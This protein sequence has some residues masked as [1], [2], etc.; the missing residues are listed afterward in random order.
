MSCMLMMMSIIIRI[1]FVEATTPC[2][3]EDPQGCDDVRGGGA[4]RRRT[5]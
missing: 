4:G 5:Q 1:A 3:V 2:K